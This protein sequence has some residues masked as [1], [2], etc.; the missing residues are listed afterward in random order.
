MNSATTA[1]LR[2]FTLKARALLETEV[3]EQL[4][5]IYGWL[6]GGNLEPAERYP[7]IQEIDEARKVRRELERFLA[8][9]VDAGIKPNEA[10]DDL[11]REAAFTWLNRLVAFK[12]LEARNLIRQCVSRGVQCR[13]FL[14]WLTEAGN[15]DLYARYEQ[16]DLPQNQLG[17]GPRQEAYRR[18]ILFQC[19]K[20]ALEIRVL[21]DP[22]NLASRFFPRPPA[23]QQLVMWMNEPGIEE[24][25]APGN[26]ET[27]GWVYQYFNELEK[28]DVFDRLYKKKQKIRKEDVPAATQ[29]FT[30]NWIVKWLVQ[31]TL[32]QYWVRMHPD[33]R[34]TAALPYLVPLAGKVPNLP[35]RRARDIRLMDPA[36]GTMHFGSEAFDL[37]AAMYREEMERAGSPGWPEKPSIQEEEE[38]PAAIIA[39]NIHGI[40]I[41]LR[42]VQLSALTLY[43]KAKALSPKAVITE[44]RLGCASVLQFS[45]EKLDRLLADLKLKH[46]IYGAILR[47][48]WEELCHLETG[49]SLVRLEKYLSEAVQSGKKQLDGRLAS[50]VGA[51]PGQFETEEGTREFWE[52]IENQVI[53]ALNF[54]AMHEAERGSGQAFF[55]REMTKGFQVLDLMLRRYDVVVTNPP[56]MT[57]RNMNPLLVSFLQKEYPESKGDL[58]TAFIER[59]AE[60]LQEGGRLGMITQQ[61]FMFISSYEKMRCRLLG[62]SVIEAM[63]HVGP[64]AFESIS[65]E[66]VNTTLFALRRESVAD[67]RQEAIGTYFRLVKE[68]DG[69]SKRR[70][71]ELALEALK[72]GQNDPL[73]F[74][75]RQGDFDA[76]P[77]SPWVYWVTEAVK[78]VF[79][80]CPRLSELAKVCIG[81]RTGDNFRFLRYWWETGKSSIAMGCSSP[82]EVLSNSKGWIPYMKGGTFRRWY[83]NQEYVVRWASNGLE[84]K[85]NTRAV[86]PQL[87]DNLGWKI[88]NEEQYFHRGVT[89][90]DLTS[91]RF[92]AR[93]SPGGFIFDVK[94]S[95]AFPEDIPLVLGLLN[96]A[97]AHYVLSL[98][99]PTVSFQVGDLARLPVPKISSHTLRDLVNTAVELAKQTSA[100]SETTYDFISPPPWPTG[101]DSVADRAER[102]S[103]IERE[104]D[105]EVYRLYGISD[106]DRQAIERELA[107]KASGLTNE[108]DDV[109][110]EES[111]PRADQKSEAQN[112]ETAQDAGITPRLTTEEL[113]RQWISYA[114][115]IVLGRFQ[116]GVA[117][118]LGCGRFSQNIASSLQDLADPDGILVMD[119]GHP[120]DLPTKVLQALKMMV[121]EEEAADVIRAG[122]EKRGAPEDLLRQY[123]DRTFFKQH[124]QQYR[125]RPV[126]W[127]LQSPKKRYGI[128]AFHERLTNDTLFRIQKE[129]VGPKINHLDAQIADL[130]AKR[131]GAQG[132]ERRE[133]EKTMASLADILDDV[134]EFKKILEQIIQERGY[135]PHLDD[136]VL[137]NMAPLWELIASWQAGPKKAWQALECGDYDWSYQAM[138]HWPDRVR[139]TC[140]TNKSCA[141]AHGLELM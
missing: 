125:K 117:K 134:R 12:M 52:I 2:D 30:P 23:L 93:L 121:G 130:R 36:C 16:G 4:E 27:I 101:T 140:K 87:G 119:E 28:K 107:D 96:S 13:G 126:Y 138:D 34:L 67:Q 73:V 113:A 123:L 44:S 89:W 72:A 84:I 141:I 108:V 53:Q 55:S 104:I 60:L 98:I 118:G 94:G 39:H 6:P 69:D 112:D 92:N 105:E 99:N 1:A 40:D 51:T 46:S 111:S 22:E 56:Y 11:L 47:P 18:F 76:I 62:T 24:A 122:T 114:V 78:A 128:W 75:Y 33:S 21:F 14:L 115:G 48:L 70:R 38:I 74:R 133:L 37:F 137:L 127:Y 132:R 129:Y 88:S 77:G 85:E 110:G 54:F 91:C 29:L 102:L 139:E 71:F 79:H 97:F 106:E 58:Y 19:G 5:G 82:S 15:D 136:G 50:F 17:E 61:S 31:N 116:P 57:R 65:G 124:I 59:C 32:G 45:K 20:L 63:A 8:E 41:D 68:L 49:G 103:A 80:S 86:Y 26:E 25:W 9:S 42:S 135:R 100:E 3:R 131:D 95:S 43:L 83:G 90:T 10:R 109:D 66:K 64:R 35:L 7:A 81:M 120:D